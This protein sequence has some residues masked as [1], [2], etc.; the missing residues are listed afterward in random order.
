MF[1]AKLSY[2]TRM[3]NFECDDVRLKDLFRAQ[4]ERVTDK[5][6]NGWP[7]INRFP[8]LALKAPKISINYLCLIPKIAIFDVLWHRRRHK[9]FSG[10]KR[11]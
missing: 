5:K 7:K 9:K 8:F 1:P 10:F 4:I 6:E 2:E 3:T 11:P